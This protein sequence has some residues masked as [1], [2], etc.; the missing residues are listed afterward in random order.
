[1][2]LDLAVSYEQPINGRRG[3]PGSLHASSRVPAALM[4]ERNAT[5]V[6]DRSNSR[7]LIPGVLT[8]I[9]DGKLA[10]E[11][12]TTVLAPMDDAAAALN[13]HLQGA[14]TKTI[15]AI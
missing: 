9:A 10:P 12:V 11:R 6:F 3:A 13:A 14:S 5:L 2:R 1:M 4:F 8:P 7:A 15:V